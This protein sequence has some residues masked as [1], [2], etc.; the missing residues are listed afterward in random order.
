M[1]ISSRIKGMNIEAIKYQ[2]I[3]KLRSTAVVTALYLFKLKSF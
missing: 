2:C 1:V 3:E